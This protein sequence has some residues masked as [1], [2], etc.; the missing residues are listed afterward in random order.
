MGTLQLYD[1]DCGFGNLILD[2]VL[3]KTNLDT[4][5]SIY[6]K[7]GVVYTPTL[8]LTLK[9]YVGMYCSAL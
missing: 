4:A 7:K 3:K 5:M 2:F 9:P 8:H 1:L 6:P